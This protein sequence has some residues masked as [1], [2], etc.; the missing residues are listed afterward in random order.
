[1]MRGT[2]KVKRIKDGVL[3]KEPLYIGEHIVN[4]ITLYTAVR[5]DITPE[6]S[7]MRYFYPNTDTASQK[8][9]AERAVCKN[10][11]VQVDWTQ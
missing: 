2:V 7:L 4:S 8:Y 5:Y 6:N 3:R 1:M 11:I 9:V 10:K